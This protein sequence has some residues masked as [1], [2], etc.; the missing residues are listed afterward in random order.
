MNIITPLVSSPL[1]ALSIAIL[2]VVIVALLIGLLIM[3]AKRRNPTP[4]VL[5]TSG[6]TAELDRIMTSTAHAADVSA[7]LGLMEGLEEHPDALALIQD[8]PKTVQAAAWM[9]YINRLGSDLQAA[10]TMLSHAHQQTG[11][12]APNKYFGN[13]TSAQKAQ[14]QLVDMIRTK[15]D[16]AVVAS[17]GSHMRPVN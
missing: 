4:V 17:G 14:Q 15:L 13:I 1:F 2:L 7:V 3:L 5:D 16:A 8:Y 11:P 6:F 9:H 12:Y 10:Q